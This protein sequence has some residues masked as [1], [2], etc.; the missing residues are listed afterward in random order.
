MAKEIPEEVRQIFA[1]LPE[2]FLGHVEIHFS[3]GQPGFAKVNKTI[4]FKS[5]ATKAGSRNEYNRN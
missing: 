2:D 5:P 4:H 1:E 3:R